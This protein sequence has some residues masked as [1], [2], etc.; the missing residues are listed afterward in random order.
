LSILSKNIK[1]HW[2]HKTKNYY[3]NKYHKNEQQLDK[4]I[5]RQMFLEN[6]YDCKVF[7]ITQ[8]KNIE[9]IYESVYNLCDI[10]ILMK[11]QHRLS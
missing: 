4:D 6:E 10:L 1:I 9:D 5:K 8:S 2:V 11:K 3:I 7:R